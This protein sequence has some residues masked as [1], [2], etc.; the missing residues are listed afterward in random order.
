MCLQLRAEELVYNENFHPTEQVSKSRGW[1][2]QLGGS[3]HAR[4]LGGNC[5]HTNNIV[6]RA[7]L[8]GLLEEIADIH[9]GAWEPEDYHLPTRRY[10]DRRIY[11]C[12]S[13]CVDPFQRR[14]EF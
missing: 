10:C 13:R 1:E 3:S 11:E 12:N 14:L 9:E 6:L 5:K 2:D 4:V 8:S 7:M